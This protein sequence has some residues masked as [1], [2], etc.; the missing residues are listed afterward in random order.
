M[1]RGRCVREL[2]AVKRVS[3]AIA[4]ASDAGP[5]GVNITID[6]GPDPRWTPQVLDLL[7]EEGVKATFGLTGVQ[8]QAHPDLVKEIVADGHVL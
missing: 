8:A 7:R 1:A 3:P 6:D 2:A 5:R 4:H